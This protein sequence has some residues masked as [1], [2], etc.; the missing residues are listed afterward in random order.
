CCF[1]DGLSDRPVG[2]LRVEGPRARDELAH[3][4]V[5]DTAGLDVMPELTLR[6]SGDR[7]ATGLVGDVFLAVRT[8]L[9]LAGELAVRPGDEFRAP[10]GHVH[11]R[12]GDEPLV[13]DRRR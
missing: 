8:E 2:G 7:T 6:A 11:G 5:D 1:L 9:G 12:R 4:W 3:G 10:V 13:E